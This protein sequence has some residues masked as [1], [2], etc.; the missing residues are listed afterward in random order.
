VH[1]ELHYSDVLLLPNMAEVNSRSD[2]FIEQTLGN[3]HWDLPVVPANMKTIID[4][5]LAKWLVD[6]N[7]FYIM[8]RFGIDTL[9]FAKD[10]YDAVKIVSISIGVNDDSKEVIT[11]LS[12][13]K[14]P[15]DYVTIDIAHGHSPKMRDMLHFIKIALPK[16]FVIAGNVCTVEG[17]EDLCM[18][19]ADA[20]KVGVA[21]GKVCITKLQ[22]GFSR[23]QFTAVLEC[24]S[25]S[26]VPIIA[27]GGI[28]ETG[29]I[30]KALVA[31]ASWVMT[32]NL[33]AG[34]TENPSK[35]VTNPD[36]FLV[37]EYYGSASEHNKGVKEYVEGCRVEIPYR[38]AIE[39]KYKEIEQGLRSSISY[40]GGHDLSAFNHVKWVVQ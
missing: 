29:D 26:K 23:P 24:A 8:H 13:Q 31:G 5:N 28:S 1:K 18:W 36:G 34:Y 21:S 38:G 19:G 30:A 7:H 2:V 17:T 12:E 35:L 10:I 33:L 40:A 25:V 37:K 16:V 15:I 14:I 39:G 4:F 6:H 27:D 32:G 3:I 20:V 9:Q 22:T 11:K